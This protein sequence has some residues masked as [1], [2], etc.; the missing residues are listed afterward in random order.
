MAPSAFIAHR[1]PHRLRIKIPSQKGDEDYFSQLQKYFSRQPGVERVEVNPLTG[2]LLILTRAASVN[3]LES[4]ASNHWFELRQEVANARPV[5]QRMLQGFRDMDAQ[6]EKFTGGEV[7]IAGVA[8]IGLIIAGIYQVSIG[9]FA[10]PAWYTAFWY[11]TSIAVKSDRATSGSG[12][13]M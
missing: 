12:G 11:A 8:M 5:S 2:S 4:I 1:T 9:N 6:V 10:A 13:L 7:D 3:P